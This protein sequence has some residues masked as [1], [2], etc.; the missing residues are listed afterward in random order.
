VSALAGLDL[1]RRLEALL[2]EGVS[3]GVFPSAAA[4]VAVDD[5]PAAVAFA[6]PVG[7]RTRW[8]L[9]SLTKPMVTATLCMRGVAAGWLA[10]DEPAPALGEPEVTVRDLLAHRSGLPALTDLAAALDEALPGWRPG[11]PETRAAARAHI[12]GLPRLRQPDGSRPTLYSDLGYIVLAELLEA[13]LG[14]PLAALH[15]GFGGVGP[16]AHPERYAP[17]RV[18]ERRGR[19]LQGEVDDLN[20][21]VLGGAAGHAGLFATLDA[22]AAWAVDLARAAAGRPASLDGA[23][24]REFWDLDQRA[25]AHGAARPTWVLGFDT[26]TPGASSAGARVSPHAVGHLGFTGTSVWIDRHDGLVM[27]LLSH[28]TALGPGTQGPMRAFRPRFH[29]AARALL[30]AG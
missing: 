18:C 14:R 10:L 4:Y 19:L 13:R 16:P 17:N 11:A 5:R 21:W 24:V 9:A 30:Q 6:G 27:V 1:S 3:E 20:A 8:D 25:P 7:P 2:A 23:V 28:R 12:L 22:V 29:D 15:P 26:P